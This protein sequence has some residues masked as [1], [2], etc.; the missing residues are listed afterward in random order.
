MKIRPAILKIYFEG[1]GY[2][3]GSLAAWS[4]LEQ[5]PLTWNRSGPL[6]DPIEVILRWEPLL[7]ATHGI[8]GEGLRPRSGRSGGGVGWS[9]ST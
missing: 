6:R 5:F 8:V 4:R 7:P 1:P 2:P 9:D 3:A